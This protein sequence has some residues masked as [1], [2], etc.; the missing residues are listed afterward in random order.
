MSLKTYMSKRRY[1]FWVICPLGLFLLLFGFFD[2][3]LAGT[4][5][6]R[7]TLIVS[8]FILMCLYGYR[9]VVYVDE[10]WG[11][12]YRYCIA[13]LAVCGLLLWLLLEGKG[14]INSAAH[15]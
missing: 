2:A 10:A 12:W 1:R 7:Y 4:L 13:S 3:L 6:L 8:Y 15:C 11:C 14:C 9:L 5:D